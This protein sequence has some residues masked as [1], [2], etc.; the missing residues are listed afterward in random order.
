MMQTQTSNLHLTHSPRLRPSPHSLPS[1]TSSSFF[2]TLALFLRLDSVHLSQVFDTDLV[3]LSR[4][5]WR[6]SNLAGDKYCFLCVKKRREGENERRRG[7][8]VCSALIP[9]SLPAGKEKHHDSHS[10][11]LKHQLAAVNE[12][13][14]AS[15]F[16]P[17]SPSLS[18]TSFLRTSLPLLLRYQPR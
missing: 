2:L 3:K 4:F 16:L 8:N 7:Q 1:F 12:A 13:S 17:L 5:D 11:R 15:K 10:Q 14:L 18:F 9:M 6:L